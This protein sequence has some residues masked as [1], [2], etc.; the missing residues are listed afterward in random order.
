[1]S[2]VVEAVTSLPA[3]LA[4]WLPQIEKCF[5]GPL[6]RLAANLTIDWNN[7][8]FVALCF[9]TDRAPY[10]V[11][12]HPDHPRTIQR[13]VPWR[14]GNRTES[15]THADLIQMFLPQPFPAVA[16]FVNLQVYQREER[17]PWYIVGEI[18]IVPPFNERVTLLGNSVTGT[19]Y[20]PG[21]P[22]VFRCK[23]SGITAFHPPG[24]TRLPTGG[25]FIE[26]PSAVGIDLRLVQ[27]PSHWIGETMEATVRF[28]PIGGAPFSVSSRLESYPP[29]EG[30][31]RNYRPI[32]LP[33]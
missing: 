2:G 33:S 25:G 17:W 20:I 9:E 19:L 23:H 14:V 4:N 29:E 3:E 1:M 12:A 22:S 13:E 27:D 21:T 30:M 32:D 18:L 6:P 10:V 8:A 28:S 7:G 15:A 31:V 24:A 5:H 16:A 11:N 26:R